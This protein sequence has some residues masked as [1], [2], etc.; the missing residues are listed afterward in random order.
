[1]STFGLSELSD[2]LLSFVRERD[3]EQ[4]HSPK[5]LSMAISVEA[6]ELAEHF[7]WTDPRATCDISAETREQVELEIADVFLYLLR[8][9]QVMNIDL[10]AAAC[11]K[12]EINATK[13][14]ADRV[15]GSSKKYSDYEKIQ[16]NKT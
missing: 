13:Y 15:R 8:M 12:L 10:V 6:A 14:P 3:W 9:A 2:A 16:G 7:L 4:F 1:M 5:N 11:K